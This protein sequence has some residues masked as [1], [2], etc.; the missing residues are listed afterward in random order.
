MCSLHCKSS[1]FVR[2]S[3]CKCEVAENIKEYQRL[4]IIAKVLFNM[5]YKTKLKLMG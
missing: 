2:Q 5:R 4:K 1:N 3:C